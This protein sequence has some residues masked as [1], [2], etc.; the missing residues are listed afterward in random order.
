MIKQAMQINPGLDK[1]CYTLQR[2]LVYTT[3]ERAVG[4][5]EGPNGLNLVVCIMFFGGFSQE[6][7]IIV[8]KSSVDRVMF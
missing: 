7:A 6:D 8:T 5:D 2:P 4:Y 3:V 1:A